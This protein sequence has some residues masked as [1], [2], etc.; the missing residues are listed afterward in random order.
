MAA[1]PRQ[2]KIEYDTPA[3][4]TAGSGFT[5]GDTT[6]RQIHSKDGPIRIE[7]SWDSFSL[8]F[9]FVTVSATAA[10]FKTEVDAVEEALRTPYNR[11][12]VT[13]AGQVQ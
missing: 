9:S 11:L 12:R 6:A 7:R 5:V 8:E 4:V 2:F 13:M 10:A 3:A 1:A